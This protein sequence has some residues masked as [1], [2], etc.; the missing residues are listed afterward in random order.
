MNHFFL[1]RQWRYW[2]NLS[3]QNMRLLDFLNAHK[4]FIHLENAT[5]E[6]VK[7]SKGQ[8]YQYE[9]SHTF[10]SPQ[11]IILAHER[12]PAVDEKTAL[13]E[14]R[15]AKKVARHRYEFFLMN[16]MHL[17]GNAALKNGE[18]RI[19]KPFIAI[20]DYLL[21]S[22]QPD[23]PDK[24]GFKNLSK[25]APFASFEYLILNTTWI[26]HFHQLMPHETVQRLEFYG[27]PPA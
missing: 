10:L 7:D 27:L 3:L 23:A 9:M 18:I 2:A 15:I 4:H 6:Q 14:R 8:P 16:D 24:A 22:F 5:I 13:Y 11:S 21:V 17:I 25:Q 1:T 20:T 26:Q 12:F 19:E